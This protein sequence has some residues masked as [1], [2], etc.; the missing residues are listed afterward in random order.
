MQ[1]SPIKKIIRVLILL[2]FIGISSAH[3][4]NRSEI[5]K[6]CLRTNNYKK[7]IKEFT[8]HERARKEG[9]SQDPIEIEV[10]PFIK[11]KR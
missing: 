2:S 6:F 7:C 8:G 9:N 4:S 10:V 3:S 11:N 5:A 1:N